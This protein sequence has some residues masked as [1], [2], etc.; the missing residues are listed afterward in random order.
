MNQVHGIYEVWDFHQ[1]IYA[2]NILVSVLDSKFW[3]FK[4]ASF[5]LFP[6]K[7]L[8][9]YACIYTEEWRNLHCFLINFASLDA[10][11]ANAAHQ[12]LK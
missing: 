4:F 8:K 7:N 6:L 10:Y 1:N 11:N 9:I 3:S 12:I 5:L 2:N